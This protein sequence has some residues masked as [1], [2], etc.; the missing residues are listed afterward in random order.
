MLES[1]MDT[2]LANK[3]DNLSFASIKLR[4]K[5]MTNRFM[6]NRK[7]LTE[8]FESGANHQIYS[9]AMNYKRGLLSKQILKSKKTKKF[10]IRLSVVFVAR[11]IQPCFLL[12]LSLSPKVFPL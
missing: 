12:Q 2:K 1:D 5:D 10:Y 4:S 11:S 8:W 9:D 6:S 7:A 3:I